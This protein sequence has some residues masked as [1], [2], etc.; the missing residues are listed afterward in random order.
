MLAYVRE[1]DR[2]RLLIVLNLGHDPATF[3]GQEIR[4]RLA[5]STHLGR[6]G[7]RVEGGIGLRADEGVI[8][9]QG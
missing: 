1:T 9:E 5:L 7:E 4:G 8:V 6:D 3:I 2:R